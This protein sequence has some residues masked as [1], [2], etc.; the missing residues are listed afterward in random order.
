[1]NIKAFLQG[2]LINPTNPAY[3]NDALRTNNDLPTTSPYQDLAVINT[4]VL[5]DG[6]TSGLGSTSDDIVDWIW[7]EIR[8]NV[9]NTLVVDSSS[10]LIQ[11]D[12]DVV[13]LDGTSDV[14]LQGTTNSYYVVIKH[15]NHLGV[16]TGN[17]INLSVVASS[18]D[19]TNASTL[20]FG[21][22]AQV[23]L[24]KITKALWAG[25]ANNDGVVQYA[26]DTPD[27]PSILSF[28][29]ND[30]SNLLNFPTHAISGYYTY[31]LDLNGTTQYSGLNPDTPFILQNVLLHPGNFLNLST[32]KITEQLPEN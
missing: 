21:T 22:N 19:F 20:T 13:D 15:R 8:S 6:G 31:D 17:P 3:M 26:G 2:P 7:V 11:R 32:Y 30:P 24:N 16:M 5:N 27:S 18:I 4:S 9:D 14:I 28:I 23:F 10:A 12:G 25:D 1:M 29:L